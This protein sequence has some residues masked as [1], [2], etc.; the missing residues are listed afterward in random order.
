MVNYNTTYSKAVYKY[1]LKTFYSKINKKMYN[2]QIR[3]HNIF[4]TNI[5]VM[6]DIIILAETSKDNKEQLAIENINK[7]VIAKVAKMF[8]AINF[9]GK[10][11]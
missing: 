2:S 3:Q 6:K 7:T 4:Y 8:N 5:T 9:D 11:R 10:Y 1:L